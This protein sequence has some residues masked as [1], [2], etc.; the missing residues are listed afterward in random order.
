MFGKPIDSLNTLEG[1]K[2]S[3]VRRGAIALAAVGVALSL[4]ACTINFGSAGSTSEHSMMD[5]SSTA[6]FSSDD[7]MFAAMMIPHH[8][9]AVDMSNLALEKSSNPEVRTLATQIRD[10][11]APEIKQMQGWLDGS[12]G[13]SMSDMMAGHGGMMGGML[14]DEQLTALQNASGAAFDR[15]F[16][17][18]MIAHHEG[19]I[20]M[21]T[22]I[23]S[24]SN[25][26]AH[27]LGHNIVESQNAE[28]TKMKELLAQLG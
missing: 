17:E 21:A 13:A 11:Q 1:M 19:A 6:G 18:G 14:T 7:L 10:A 28:I 24:S 3:V 2:N 20:A 15:L 5:H 16:L 25:E 4:S 8:Q 26:E 12:G 9:Q 27:E 22:M 23:T